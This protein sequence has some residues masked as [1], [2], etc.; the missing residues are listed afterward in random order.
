MSRRC[1]AGPLF[2]VA[3][4]LL[5]QLT[6]QTL[7]RRN[8]KLMNAK[9]K[10]KKAVSYL[11]DIIRFIHVFSLLPEEV[12]ARYGKVMS[13]YNAKIKKRRASGSVDESKNP[14]LATIQN[15]AKSLVDGGVGGLYTLVYKQNGDTEWTS[16][17]SRD[18]K[19]LTEQTFALPAGS[20]YFLFKGPEPEVK[21]GWKEADIMSYAKRAILVDTAQNKQVQDGALSS[22]TVAQIKKLTTGIQADDMVKLTTKVIASSLFSPKPP[23]SP[24][25]A[26]KADPNALST[27]KEQGSLEQ[28]QQ[29]KV[30]FQFDSDTVREQEGKRSRS[31]PIRASTQ[32]T[33]KQAK[34]KASLTAPALENSPANP[35]NE[36]V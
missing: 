3:L 21:A 19:S 18:K 30:H 8:L 31:T 11:I 25:G 26:S 34:K 27:V 17:S 33:P 29:R 16:K 28:Q 7:R 32:Q 4:R 13:A 1:I 36:Y 5:L 35:S 22:T 20:F 12:Q 23:P 6:R 24:G 2:F 10:F 15:L 14:A 9:L